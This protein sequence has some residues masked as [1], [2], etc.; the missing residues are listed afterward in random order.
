MG[1]SLFSRINGAVYRF[2]NRFSR[3]GIDRFLNEQAGEINAVATSETRVLN[4]GSGGLVATRVAKINKAA[5]ISFDIDPERR[6]HAVVDVCDMACIDNETFDRIFMMEVL[7]HVKS[8]VD[9]VS[10]CHRVLKPGGSLFL[11]VPFVF[12]IHDRPNDYFRY[13]E[14]GLEL[15]LKNFDAVK[16]VARNTYLESVLVL[17][18]RLCM[19]PNRS[20]KFFPLI[21]IGTLITLFP[22]WYL[23]N[24]WIRSDAA[25]SGYIVTCTK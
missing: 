20:E 23:L 17:L 8:P 16:I 14:H 24:R 25:T 9:A 12:E 1:N 21:V 15:L 19:S 7:E 3:A 13:T 6:P 4:I 5:V 11:S 18:L 2:T 22:L 10:E